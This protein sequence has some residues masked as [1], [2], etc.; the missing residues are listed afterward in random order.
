MP[1]FKDHVVQSKYLR[2]L[3]YHG[4]PFS[5][6]AERMSFN[7]RF[8]IKYKWEGLRQAQYWLCSI[9]SQ[10]KGELR[11]SAYARRNAEAKELFNDVWKLYHDCA[12]EDADLAKKNKKSTKNTTPVDDDDSD[13]S[14]TAAPKKPAKPIHYFPVLPCTLISIKDVDK[15]VRDSEKTAKQ[16]KSKEHKEK[17]EKTSGQLF[18]ELMFVK[19][20]QDGV[21]EKADS[22]KKKKQS[23]EH[24]EK[25]S[26]KL[27]S[28]S[29][30]AK[31]LQ[32]AVLEKA[33]A[34]KVKK[35]AAV[36]GEEVKPSG[37]PE[38]KEERAPRNNIFLVERMAP[39]KESVPV[40]PACLMKEADPQFKSEENLFR[41]AGADNRH[42]F[43]R[44][45]DDIYP[46][47]SPLQPLKQFFVRSAPEEE[48]NE[49]ELMEVEE[50]ENEV[51]KELENEMAAVTVLREEKPLGNHDHDPLMDELLSTKQ[52][53]L[54][55]KAEVTVG[56]KARLV[57]R[58]GY[59]R[60]LRRV[61]ELIE[62]QRRKTQPS[63]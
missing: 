10:M 49:E 63:L 33:A 56:I 55:K 59:I 38:F 34:P 39:A 53:I 36:V 44:T 7:R 46:P 17:V 51:E 13:K 20:K 19:S 42:P 58:R 31:P 62:K 9:W 28:K 26:G 50:V 29:M 16:K 2:R 41:P 43:V 6:R 21:L 4:R 60:M 22:E 57:N 3:L 5:N 54:K 37:F 27:F 8:Y 40:K 11:K 24:V 12:V 61:D 18:L 1:D 30:F 25:T 48:L 47:L 35:T 15:N 32:T 14:A 23:K 52:V 45:F